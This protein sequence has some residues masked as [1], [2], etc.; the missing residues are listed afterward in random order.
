M[1]ISNAIEQYFVGCGLFCYYA[2]HAHKDAETQQ[3]VAVT[4]QKMQN[5][6]TKS[7]KKKIP[8]KQ[9]WI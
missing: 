2:V 5:V 9:T 6:L 4:F 3:M 7:R 8:S 1:T